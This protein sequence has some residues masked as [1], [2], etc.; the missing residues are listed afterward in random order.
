MASLV[1]G[2]AVRAALEGKRPVVALESAVLSHGLPYPLSA[3]VAQLLEEVVREE[4][5]EAATVGVIRGQAKVGLSREESLLLASG[6]GVHKISRRDLPLAVAK[7]WDGGTTVSATLYLA[8]RAGLKVMATGGIGGVHRGS[9]WDV[10]ADLWELARTPMVVVSSGPKAI[11]DLPAT[12]ERLETYGVLIVGYGCDQLPAFYSRESG[13]PLPYR[14]DT[15]EE[16]G[17]LARAREELGISAAILV[18]VPVPEADVV[19]LSRIERALGKALA[20]AEAQGVKGS[21]LTPFLLAQMNSLTKGATLKANLSLLKN[22]ARVAAQIAK[23][24]A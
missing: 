5:A 22:N 14:V 6:Q 4:G 16:V 2:E 23:A 19:P 10:S 9:I 11:L 7:G 15:P 12:L 21:A 8:H 24:M 3:E 20:M 17:E 18:A 13:L 1:I